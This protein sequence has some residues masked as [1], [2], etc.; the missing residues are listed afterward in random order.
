MKSMLLILILFLA[1]IVYVESRGR[2]S[3]PPRGGQLN[4]LPSPVFMTGS[5]KGGVVP[6]AQPSAGAAI[7]M[8]SV[9]LTQ[10]QIEDGWS[11]PKQGIFDDEFRRLMDLLRRKRDD[12]FIAA[13]EKDPLFI[14]YQHGQLGTLLISTCWFER[15]KSAQYL[16]EH[17]ADLNIISASGET[18]LSACIQT[19]G[20]SKSPSDHVALMEL[21]LKSG[22]DAAV[23]GIRRGKWK[24]DRDVMLASDTYLEYGVKLQRSKWYHRIPRNA[25]LARLR[26]HLD[27]PCDAMLPINANSLYLIDDQ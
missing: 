8:P 6:A 12:E 17:G 5:S 20:T 10:Q 14:N 22:A 27:L 26:D 21:L 1:V 25:V 23:V 19:A 4:S 13:L 18:P 24:T 7:P 11:A 16:I 15:L 3:A 2:S 9:R